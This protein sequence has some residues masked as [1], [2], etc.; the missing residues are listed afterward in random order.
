M[1]PR[2]IFVSVCKVSNFWSVLNNSTAGLP[3]LEA[4]LLY[5]LTVSNCILRVYI[6]PNTLIFKDVTS[7]DFSIAV[8]DSL[9]RASL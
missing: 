5:Q 6:P 2:E 1:I 4:I 8:K 3:C 9:P 7:Q